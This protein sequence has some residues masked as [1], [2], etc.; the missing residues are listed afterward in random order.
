MYPGIETWT[1]SGKIKLPTKSTIGL[2][3]AVKY[4]VVFRFDSGTLQ[5][6]D[7]VQ[8]RLKSAGAE[9]SH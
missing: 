8:A 2:T 9:S 6:R 1:I 3:H 4:E 5:N 7:C